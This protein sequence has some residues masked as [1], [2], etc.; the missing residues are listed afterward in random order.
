M[1]DGVPLAPLQRYAWFNL[2]V[3]AIAVAL[4]L[5]AV[6]ILRVAFSHN[7]DSCGVALAGSLRSLRPLGVR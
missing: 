5:M 6:P 4:Y 1:K 2:I 7:A 3:F